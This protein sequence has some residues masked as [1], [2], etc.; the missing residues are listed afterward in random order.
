MAISTRKD[1]FR[2]SRFIVEIEGIIQSSFVEVVMPT[3]S[4]DTVE[5]RDGN[6][7]PA[8]HKIP[9]LT[10]FSNIILKWGITD[11]L[12]LYNWYKDVED[13]KISSSRKK[14]AII[15][16]DEEGKEVASWTFANAW[17]VKYTP[18]ILKAE[19]N[20]IAIETLEVTYEGMERS[21]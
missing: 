17:P 15:L 6:E 9:G 2:N 1:P 18:P 20:E 19:A 11:S 5:Y 14:I 16:L 8:V 21:K 10:K 4:L 7:I 12:E 13:G 3:G